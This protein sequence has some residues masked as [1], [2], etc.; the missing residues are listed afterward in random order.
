MKRRERFGGIL[1]GSALLPLVLCVVGRRESR[2]GGR[3][4]VADAL[5]HPVPLLG[6]AAVL[7]LVAALVRGRRDLVG[8]ATAAVGSAGL[9]CALGVL[10]L[11]SFSREP[12]QQ[13]RTSSPGRADHVL[14]VIHRGLPGD[15]TESQSRQVRLET[16]TGWSA[17]RWSVLTMPER[18]PGEGAFR[19]AA[20]T[21]PDRITV[22]T[23]T[24]SRVFTVA[25][26]SGE[27][28]LTESAGTVRGD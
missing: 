26:D 13:T 16:G 8:G 4:A 27:P 14:V 15:E 20:W 19:S 23:D 24:G 25:P 2:S 18:F 5:D 3:F 22:T 12:S 21:A 1:A 7:L 28:T 10:A 11:H 9:L 17:R 6:A